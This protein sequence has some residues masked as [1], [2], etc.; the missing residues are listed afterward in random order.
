MVVVG[1]IVQCN[2]GVSTDFVSCLSSCA[3][4]NTTCSIE[5]NRH[6][7]EQVNECPCNGGCPNGCP[8]PVYECPAIDAPGIDSILVLHYNDGN[9][10]LVTNVDGAVNE[11]D[12]VTEGE[13]YLPSH[14]SLQFKNQ[15]FIYGQV[16][17]TK[18][19]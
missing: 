14:C 2:S 10:A 16:F 4:D 12:W 1:G 3:P 13:V 11:L 8:C 7:N 15:M 18:L 9:K 19:S 17:F 6:Y 5:C